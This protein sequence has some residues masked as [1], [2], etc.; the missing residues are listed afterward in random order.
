MHLISLHDGAGSSN[1]LGITGNLDRVTFSPYFTFKDLITIFIL[2]FVLSV[3]VALMP[4]VLGDSENYI[5]ANPMQTPP[6]IVPEWYILL[7][8]CIL[9][10]LKI[11]RSGSYVWCYS[12][13]YYTA[14]CG[15]RLFYPKGS[16]GFQFRP[17][18]KFALWGAFAANFLVLM[19]LGACHVE[20]PFI[21]LEQISTVFYFSYFIIIVPVLSVIDNIFVDLLRRA[22][23]FL[24]VFV[25]TCNC[26][27]HL[28]LAY[29][30]PHP[31]KAHTKDAVANERAARKYSPRTLAAYYSHPLFI[32]NR[33]FSSKR[34]FS[35]KLALPLDENFYEWFG[36]FSDGEAMFYIQLTAGGR[37]AVFF[38][39]ISLHK[40]DIAVLNFIKDSL[41]IGKVYSEAGAP[42][43]SF[44]VSKKAEVKVITDTPSGYPLKTTKLLNFLD[45]KKAFELY[46]TRKTSSGMIEEKLAKI[47]EEIRQ[48]KE[49]T[50]S[51][52]TDFTMPKGYKA[53]IT[54]YWLLG[55]ME[56]ESSFSVVKSN[57]YKLR[58]SIGQSSKDLAL[59]K[60]IKL[61]LL[62][63]A[64]RM[65][66]PSPFSPD[67]ISVNLVKVNKGDYLDMVHLD[68]RRHEF[69]EQVIIPF[70]DKLTWRTKKY[71]DFLDFK[72]ILELRNW[73]AQ[74]DGEGIKV[75]DLILSQMNNNRLSTSKST[76]SP[77][78]RQHLNLEIMKILA[79]PSNLERLADGRIFIKSLN[80][81]YNPAR[82]LN[83]VEVMDEDN[84]LI[85][86]FNSITAC[87]KF[88]GLSNDVVSRTLLTK[89]KP[90]FRDS[91]WLYLK[92]VTNLK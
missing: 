12:S 8:Y 84:N 15:P 23:P 50:N 81:F 72:A 19:K 7:F 59:M 65:N 18:I 10:S 74:Y 9:R 61:Y 54:D 21:T 70:F 89:G 88:F 55:F 79:R 34:L 17:L 91:K 1:P 27:L 28:M 29:P 35:T 73:G 45:F 30:Y 51:S 11:I 92:R 53:N 2:I 39:K 6:A 77:V 82:G 62:N 47:S 33:A 68:I 40:D 20:E 71:Q 5:M 56:G 86:T 85:Y 31:H 3:F 87:A 90:L 14:F 37:N 80:K 38:F 44:V 63:L 43:A 76:A 52:R 67:S 57:N 69:I 78:D 24:L 49:G 58:F 25:N 48:I 4:N 41:G 13:S 16:P 32:I 22:T 75:L 66:L 64:N 83:I 60:E 42:K 36:G 46:H 26:K